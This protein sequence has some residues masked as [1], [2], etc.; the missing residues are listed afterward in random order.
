MTMTIQAIFEGG[1]LR[2]VVPLTLPEGETVALT[3][4]RTG[5][6]LRGP[7]PVEEEYTRRVKAA[8]SLDELYAVMATA[9]PLPEGYDLCE[10]LNANRR[11]TGC[12]RLI[13]W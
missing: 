10:A 3:I 7:N 6:S 2:P 12:E 11:A 8:R 1:V 4:V 13:G 9:P 5:P